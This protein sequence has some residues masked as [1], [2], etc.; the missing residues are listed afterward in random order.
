MR[1]QLAEL[2]NSRDTEQ[3]QALLKDFTPEEIA[4]AIRELPPGDRQLALQLL[5]GETAV[6]V[7]EFLGPGSEV[8]AP[9]TEDQALVVPGTVSLLLTERQFDTLRSMLTDMNPVD[10]A[11]LLEQ[12]SSDEEVVTFRLLPKDLAVDAFEQ[13]EGDHQQQL[14]HSFTDER[15]RE[16]VTAMSPDDRARLLDEVPAAVTRRLVQLLPP[17]ERQAT[18]A[19]LGY[20]ENSAGR[21]MT[22]DY[23]DLRVNMTVAQALE[24]IRRLAVDKE[25]IYYTYVVDPGRKLI[26]T[27][28]LKDLVIAAPDSVIQ[29]IMTPAIKS[30]STQTDQE[31]VAKV[32]RDYDL[33]AVPVVDAEDRLV[34][35]VTWDD[36][37]DVM[38]EEA[39]E[40]IYRYGAVP[41]T[42]RAYFSVS[43]FMRTWRRAPWLM[44][45][46][47]VGFLTGLMIAAQEELL[48]QVAILAAFIPLLV[49]TGGNIGAQSSTVVIRGL[50]TGEITHTRAIR[51]LGAEGFVG[52]LLATLLGVLSFGMGL[53]LTGGDA[54]VATVVGATMAGIAALAAMVGGGLPFLFRLVK[55]DPAVASA[56][57]VTTV[58]DVSGVLL[59]FVIANAL[60]EIV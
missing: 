43:P 34:G 49:D 6:A 45:L 21:I 8:D 17:A 28:S 7:F 19:L 50:A 59:Y 16:L 41:M 53:V 36:V 29:D 13:M 24:R 14:I 51:T 55:V 31:E 60:L 27:A 48:E 1:S 37:L 40:D 47:A 9:L 38:E 52:L 3:A 56:P 12:L 20:N 26:G 11:R 46:I 10:V 39:T 35:I 42:E 22:P 57:L 18:L 33:L 30:V 15:A 54:S 58:M 32:L 25:T 4:Q 2:L 44:V 23:V 5:D